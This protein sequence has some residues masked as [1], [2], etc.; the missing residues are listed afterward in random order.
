M[1]GTK[2]WKQ[3]YRLEELIREICIIRRD[4]FDRWFDAFEQQERPFAQPSRRAAKRV[5]HRFFDDVMVGSTL[6]FVEE[7]RQRLEESRARVLAEKERA[8]AANEAKT[9]FISSVS[10]ELRTPLV[11]ILMEASSL[12][13]DKTVSEK[14]REAGRTIEHHARLEGALIDDLLDASRSTRELLTLNRRPMDVHGCLNDALSFCA[15]DFAPKEIEPQLSLSAEASGVS[16]DYARLL[17]VFC[18]LLRNAINLS[19]PAG[20]VA[21]T[22]RNAAG[23]DPDLHSG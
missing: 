18:T 12:A 7:Q 14:T 11:P 13:V 2:R 19:P 8:E 15:L 17:R 20:R 16:G 23:V 21:V 6:Q 10:H 5:V 22:T 1:H 3:G 9:I 4:F